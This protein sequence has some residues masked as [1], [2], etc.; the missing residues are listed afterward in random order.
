MSEA[1]Q[2][3][4]REF[5]YIL[6]YFDVQLRQIFWYWVIGMAVVQDGGERGGQFRHQ[7]TSV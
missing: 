2:A 6:Y 1:F 3:V 7:P 5:I 4:R